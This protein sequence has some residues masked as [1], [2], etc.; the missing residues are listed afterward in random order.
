MRNI[1]LI[2]VGLLVGGALGLRLYGDEPKPDKLTLKEAETIAVKNHPRISAA[3]LRAMAAKQTVKQVRS[4]F[5][6]SV[7]ADATAV[8]T[9]NENTRIAAGALNNPAIYDRNAEGVIISQLL[10]D[11]GRTANLTSSAKARAQAE[12]QNAA[13]TREQI[14]LVVNGAY[15]GVLQAQEV[16]AVAQQTVDSRQTVLRQFKALATNQL[17]SELDVSFVAV[18]V[19]DAQLLLAKART[20]LDA[21]FANLSTA[22]GYRE[23]RRFELVPEPS[24]PA[25]TNDI[26]QLTA[27]ALRQRPE[28]LQLRYQ[29][30]AAVQFAR[31]EKKVILPTINAVGSAGLIP[32]RDPIFNDKY[33]AAGVNLALPLFTGGLYASRRRE[34]EFRAKEA[35]QTLRDEEDTVMRDVR[36]AQLNVE[37]SYQRIGLTE[38]LLANAQ[39]SMQLI[40]V[41]VN[42]GTLSIVE[43]SMAQLNETAAQI[44]SVNARYDYLLTRAALNFQI[45]ALH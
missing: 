4:A 30:D 2:A 44:A 22:L 38:E 21:A 7:F 16:L 45:G 32:V 41:R 28:L 12:Q 9:A 34:A 26:Y 24:P 29:R 10:T 35:E 43:L 42:V 18:N 39:K 20:D 31:A 1:Y 8:G 14:L 6:P 3:E 15:F 5:F 11:F 17:K 25:M 37:Y 19:S 13:A 23:Q 33:A 27:E 40:Q 36:V